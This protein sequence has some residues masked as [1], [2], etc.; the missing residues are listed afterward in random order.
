MACETEVSFLDGAAAG[1]TLALEESLDGD[2]HS[3]P[4][5]GFQAILFGEQP[6]KLTHL[7]LSPLLKMVC[8][9]PRF[10]GRAGWSLLMVLR[11]AERHQPTHG[12][13]P[14]EHRA[15][16]PLIPHPGPF[17]AQVP[18]LVRS[19]GMVMLCF[20]QMASWKV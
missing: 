16:H 17:P 3:Q 4:Q 1:K 11:A 5:S 14:L 19:L 13:S 15:M 6:V 8:I 12:R 9:I 18:N 20:T 2:G 7:Y 10:E